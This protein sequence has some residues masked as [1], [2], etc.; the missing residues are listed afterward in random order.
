MVPKD[1][2]S[3]NGTIESK[4]QNLMDFKRALEILNEYGF[5]TVDRGKYYIPICWNNVIVL[6][7]EKCFNLHELIIKIRDVSAFKKAKPNN[8]NN[9]DPSLIGAFRIE[10]INEDYLREQCEKVLTKAKK[11]FEQDQI[12]MARRDFV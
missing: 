6:W 8:L 7:V 9:F 1:G 4:G 10:Q 12:N 2:I 3:T 11:W 5:E